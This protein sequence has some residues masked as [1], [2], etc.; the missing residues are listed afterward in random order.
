[1]EFTARLE[2]FPENSLGLES[3]IKIPESIFQSMAAVATDKRIICTLNNSFRFHCA[4]LPNKTYHYIL[5]NKDIVKKNNLHPHEDISVYIEKDNSKYGINITEEMEEVLY[6]D[7]EGN[8]WFQKLT[9]GK[10]RSLI[11]IVN[12]IKNSTGRIEKT[13]VI[14]DHLKRYKG[15]LDYQL[16]NEAFK[17]FKNDRSL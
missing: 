4:M 17:K 12:K 11:H 15:V 7:P 1:M 16:L 3:H 14:L 6:A 9:P 5:L 13:F 8:N 2:K 10:Q